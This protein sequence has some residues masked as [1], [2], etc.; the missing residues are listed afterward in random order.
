[1]AAPYDRDARGAP[2]TDVVRRMT[3]ALAARDA[4]AAAGL[5][6]DDVAYHF[7]GSNPLSGTYRGRDEV[8]TESP[9]CS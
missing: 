3:W 1:V 4:E 5:L 9:R 8:R 6:T 7:P 2:V